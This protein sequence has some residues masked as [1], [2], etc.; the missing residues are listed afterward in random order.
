MAV[1]FLLPL[2]SRVLAGAIGLPLA[3]LTIAALFALT[4]RRALK[5]AANDEPRVTLGTKKEIG[6]SLALER[7]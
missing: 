5:P 3:P 6:L 2:I 1:A 4:M 7:W